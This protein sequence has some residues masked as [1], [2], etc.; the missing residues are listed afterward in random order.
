[1][2]EIRLE[3]V[4]KYYK[5]ERRSRITAAVEDV[6]LIIRQGE[7]V[8]VTGSSGAGK[9]PLLQLICGD[10]Q[11]SRG[12]VYLGKQQISQ[13]V[14]R[15]RLRACFGQVSQTPQLMRQRTIAENLTMVART[16]HVQTRMTAPQRMEKVLRMVGLKNVENKYPVEL[17]GGECRLV[18]LARAMINTDVQ[19]IAE[20]LGIVSSVAASANIDISELTAAIGTITAVTQRSGSEAARAL[21]ALIL[22][23]TGNTEIAID[24]DSDEA[25][26]AEEI[27]A[28]TDALQKFNIATRETVDG[29]EKLRNPMEVIGDM[30]MQWEKGLLSE[31]DLND[32]VSDLG[33]KL[34]SNQLM[35]LIQNFDMYE[36]M[37]QDFAGAAGSADKEFG[38]YM[39]SWE[40]RLNQLNSAWTNFVAS[41]GIEDFIKDLISFG[42]ALLTVADSDVGRL[43]VQI[44]ALTVAFGLLSSAFKA[45]KTAAAGSSIVLSLTKIVTGGTAAAE[46]MNLLTGALLKSPLFWAVSAGLVIFA[47]GK[48]IDALTV[49]V[50]ELNEEIDETNTQI[51][52]IEG[53]IADLE[54]KGASETVIDIYLKKLA[55]LNE[56]LK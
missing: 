19:K 8:F 28:M 48:V 33:G 52:E 1:M 5:N 45:I 32:L 4:S 51:S 43:I 49:S 31:V 54:A 27:Q 41:F 50:E 12:T 47:V 20:G 35:A 37:V 26:T 15:D 6:N 24:P 17:S 30:A 21:R 2:P 36:S 23:I 44:G 42:T 55:A 14:G 40:A 39:D 22:N 3:S 13:R 29:V 38:I 46:A 18:E 16:R 56:D 11:P 9:S 10:I 7:F 53:K 25:W 34:R